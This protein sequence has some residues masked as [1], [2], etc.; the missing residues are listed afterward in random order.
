MTRSVRSFLGS[1]I[2]G[3]VSRSRER[4]NVQLWSGSILQALLAATASKC[5]CST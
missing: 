2:S 3:S 4:L 5:K 1:L